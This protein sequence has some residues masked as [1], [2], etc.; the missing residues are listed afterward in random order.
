MPCSEC[1]VKKVIKSLKNTNAEG[2]DGLSTKIIKRSCNEISSILCHIINHSFWQGVF[3]DTLNTSIVKPLHKKDDRGELV[4]YRPITLISILSKIFEKLMHS[5][6]THFLNKHNVITPE[7][8][9][10]QKNKST[11]LAIFSLI[12][13]ITESLDK[14]H[15][16]SAIFFDMSSALNFVD[17][18]IL[19]KKCELYGIRGNVLEWLESYLKDRKQCVEITR[20]DAK[21]TI[22]SYRSTYEINKFGVPQGSVLG[23]LLF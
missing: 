4:N 19:L 3:P 7:Q 13:R 22:T 9:G 12:K 16:I 1:E 15:L 20:V 18:K 14:K 10:F 21:Q 6:I 5:R 17:H 11:T 23:P 8:N 2:Y